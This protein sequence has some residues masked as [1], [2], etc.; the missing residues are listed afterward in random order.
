[1]KLI[2]TPRRAT[3]DDTVAQGMDTAITLALFFGLGF[4]LDRWLGT[5]PIFMIVLT[6][7]GAVGVFVKLRYTYEARMAEHDRQR[8]EAARSRTDPPQAAA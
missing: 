6:I 1:M 8:A 7:V 2:P 5:T 3:P 4:L